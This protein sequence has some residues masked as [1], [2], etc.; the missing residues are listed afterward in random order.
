MNK[1]ACVGDRDSVRGFMA[2]G[3]E[4][5]TADTLQEAEKTVRELAES[6]EGYPVIFVTEEYFNG[7]QPLISLYAEKTVPAIISIPG[8]N[9]SQGTGMAAIKAL[10]EKAI[11]ADIVLNS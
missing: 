6:E 8:K 4:V 9:G 3:F 5:H 10:T 1:I 7:M 2:I 11:G